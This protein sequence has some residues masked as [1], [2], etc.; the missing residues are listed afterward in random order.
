[1]TEQAHAYPSGE[2]TE[3]KHVRDVSHG[4]LP[5][6][7]RCQH[8][9]M[10][11]LAWEWNRQCLT[12]VVILLI[13]PQQGGTECTQQCS[14]GSSLCFFSSTNHCK[15]WPRFALMLAVSARVWALLCAATSCWILSPAVETR[16]WR[17]GGF[18][19]WRVEVL[20]PEVESC[21]NNPFPSWK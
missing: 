4:V 13:H 16:C 10:M 9:V 7:K 15:T 5:H 8:T 3:D 20:S 2:S 12:V 18:P 21:L 1:M 14:L 19:C 6:C 17:Q 11:S